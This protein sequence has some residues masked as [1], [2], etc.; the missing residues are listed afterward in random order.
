MPIALPN[1]YATPQDVYNQIGIEAA[2][3]RLDDQN[4][5]S[6]QQVAA[7]ADAVIGATAISVAA[8]QYPMLRGTRL[9]F[10]DAAMSMPGSSW[11]PPA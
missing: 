5:A 10:S 9:V 2:Q 4:Q 7:Q 6:G 1:L 8:I 3:L 11:K